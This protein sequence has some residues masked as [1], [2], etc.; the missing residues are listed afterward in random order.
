MKKENNKCIIKEFSKDVLKFVLMF[1]WMGLLLYIVINT[2]AILWK[3]IVSCKFMENI[4]NLGYWE[5]LFI[6]TLFIWWI[7]A[8]LYF[9]YLIFLKIKELFEMYLENL[10]ERCKK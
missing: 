4:N 8:I 9:F 2:L 7:I 3:F 10:N 5:H 6:W 1:I